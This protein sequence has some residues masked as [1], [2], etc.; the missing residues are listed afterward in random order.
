MVTRSARKRCV[1]AA[2]AAAVAAAVLS[3]LSAGAQL[4]GEP[5]ESASKPIPRNVDGTISFAGTKNDVGN[6][7]GPPG[8][9][10][11]NNVFEDALEPNRLNLPTNLSV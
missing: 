1:D 7:Q 6:W 2:V 9:S 8:T 3:L 5:G 11:A 10:L 4:S